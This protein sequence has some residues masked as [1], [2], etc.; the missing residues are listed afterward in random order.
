[1]EAAVATTIALGA[2]Q[3]EAS[4]LQRRQDFASIDFDES[5]TK[6]QIEQQGNTNARTFKQNIAS[7]VALSSV[8][9]GVGS[10]S[11]RQFG[12]A[13]FS[14]FL[15]DQESIKRASKAAEA[16]ATIQRGA[17]STKRRSRD[18]GILANTAGGVFNMMNFSGGNAS[19]G[20][21]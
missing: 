7:Q 12:S 1:M 4:R 13:S 2:A 10:S 14:N 9:G 8:R 15:R 5:V 6:L 17:A 16:S 19:G 21:K 18:L 11:A 20:S 3:L